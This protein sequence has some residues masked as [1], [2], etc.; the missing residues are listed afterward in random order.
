MERLQSFASHGNPESIAIAGM[1]PPSS[2]MAE[3]VIILQVFSEAC[4]RPKGAFNGAKG[5][6]LFKG[7]ALFGTREVFHAHAGFGLSMAAFWE[8]AATLTYQAYLGERVV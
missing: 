1:A 5:D 6:R 7:L 3:E 2:A 8:F 4:K